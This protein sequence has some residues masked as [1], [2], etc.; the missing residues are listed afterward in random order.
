MDIIGKRFGRLVVKEYDTER[1][2]YVVCECD[3]GNV[4]SIRMYSLLKTNPTKS[5]GCLCKEVVR[6]IGKRTIHDN[7]IERIAENMKYNTNFQVIENESPPKNNKSGYKGVCFDNRSGMYLAYITVHRK[8]I[9]LGRYRKI[10][11]AA[12]A[13]RYAEEQYFAPLIAAKKAEKAY[14]STNT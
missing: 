12:T 10:C 1:K 6:D 7:S 13:R 2:Y 14:I 9:Y 4:K 8:R 3:C 5:C 11:D